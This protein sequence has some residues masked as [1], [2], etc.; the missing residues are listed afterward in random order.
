M[1][2]VFVYYCQK[3]MKQL[4]LFCLLLT[5]LSLNAQNV[6]RSFKG[7]VVDSSTMAPLPDVSI[8]IYR[9]SDTSLINFGFTTPLGNFSL[10]TKSTDSLLVVI[11]LL[12]YEDF[13][14][15]EKAEDG[16]SFKN[17]GDVKLAKLPYMFKAVSVK[18]AA[19]RLKGD[20][21]EIN[22]SKFKVLPGSD[23]AQLFKKIPGFEVNVKG[24]IKV[25]GA[26][27]SKIMVDGSDF[28]G[29]NP[30]MVSKNLTADMIETVQVFDERNED[31][32]PKDN[33]TKVINLK[34]KKGKR[35]GVFGDLLGGYGNNNRYEAGAR[36]NGF[37][38]DRKM[39][40]VMNSNN[41][42]STGFDFGFN[43]WHNADYYERNGT[44]GENGITYYNSI[45]GDGNINRESNAGMTFFNEF[46]K[47]RKLS[48][49]TMISQN[50]YTSIYSDNT[51][52]G[53]NDT[54][55]RSNLDSTN[56]KGV[57]K[58]ANL[59]I[60]YTK[61]IDS[62]GAFE[63][64]TVG[65]LKISNRNSSSFN[66]IKLNQT[67]INRGNTEK[68]YETDNNT[69]RINALYRRYLRKDKRY[70]F[71]LYG[72]Y[73]TQINGGFNH[74]FTQNSFDTFNNRNN[75]KYSTN[76]VLT[77]VFGKL[78]IYKKNISLNVSADRWSQQNSTF[79]LVENA[80]NRYEKKFEQDYTNKVDSLSIEFENRLEQYT[81]KPYLSFEKKG[82][83]GTLGATFMQ[84]NIHTLNTAT[85]KGLD[86][87]YQKLL[88]QLSFSYYP[89][90]KAYVYLNISQ[91]TNFPS[92]SE[93][94]P[95]ININNTY[96]RQTGNE[97][98]N[99]QVNN[100]ISFYV[101]M[102]ALKGF[103]YL[104]NSFRLSQSD[105]AKVMSSKQNEDG[106][107]IKT[108][109]NAPGYFR[110]TNWFSTSKKITK[111]FNGNISLNFDNTKN[112]NIVNGIVSSGKYGDYNV[113]PSF[114]YSHS[115]SLEL[116]F[117]FRYSYT[118]FTNTLNDQLN[119][120]QN[121][122]GYNANIR[123]L[124]RFGMEINSSLNISDSRNVPG[125]GKIVP[126]WSA[127]LQQPLGKKSNYSLKLSA[128]DILKQ[129]TNISRIASENFINISQNNQLQRYFMLS[130]IYKIKKVG[131]EDDFDYVY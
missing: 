126:V 73:N 106:V 82:L 121:I 28:F 43:N 30:G 1:N 76:E 109:T 50:D 130:L 95:V 65:G 14:H 32:S 3:I 5:G 127:Y 78:P 40:F 100:N 75:F 92:A 111:K 4:F 112:P 68:K 103:R 25:G 87:P 19:I 31:G 83:Y 89:E 7:R 125:I 9:A 88:P 53:I 99:P 77:K 6:V 107:I 102:Y 86:I 59:E 54:L 74:Q 37:K 49:N 60:N 94:Q 56:I 18:T 22:A 42:N 91:L 52:Y 117:G 48:F 63:I 104:Y 35:N 24:E 116:N 131:G 46:S 119:Y 51:L 105:N 39:S 16:W 47:K 123:A 20:T 85:G 21:I 12:N 33:V 129:N 45:S 2:P 69:F 34:L 90:N 72:S 44:F 113:S 81:V 57:S 98:L 108:P 93:L 64:G 67:F 71:S 58:S 128:Y 26:D 62:T 66:D 70:Y 13:N 55:Q 84:M 41:I 101:N 80:S 27:V 61:Q 110:L 118:K 17:F 96:E 38:N 10:S 29:N 122:L 11:S 97:S 124:L 15:K 36:L 120:N 23:V 79:Q 8:C 114:S 115:D